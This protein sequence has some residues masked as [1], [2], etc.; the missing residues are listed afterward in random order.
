MAYIFSNAAFAFSI[1]CSVA[2]LIAGAVT[3][4]KLISWLKDGIKGFF[5]FVPWVKPWWQIT[6]EKIAR[7]MGQR[8]FFKGYISI[9]NGLN[10]NKYK[11]KWKA[12]FAP[13][14][15]R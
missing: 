13:F 6:N 4:L 7:P 11:G 15:D 14:D 3:T 12:V 8:P 5:A 10:R 2:S 9:A 1:A